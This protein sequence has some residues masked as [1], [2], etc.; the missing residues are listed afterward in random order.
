MPKTHSSKLTRAD[1]AGV[2]RQP[3]DALFIPSKLKEWRKSARQLQKTSNSQYR[4]IRTFLDSVEM[5][6][7]QKENIAQILSKV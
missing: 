7:E 3:Y 6:A 5:T 2:G 1:N 4:E